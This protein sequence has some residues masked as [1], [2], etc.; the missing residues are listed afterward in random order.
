MRDYIQKG[1]SKEIRSANSSGPDAL[2]CKFLFHH[3]ST[4]L[5]AHFYYLIPKRL[6]P[7]QALRIR[8]IILL[9]RKRIIEHNLRPA[10]PVRRVVHRPVNLVVRP[11]RVRIPGQ[12]E[13]EQVF[14]HHDRNRGIHGRAAHA[15]SART[16]P[17]ASS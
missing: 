2:L 9:N 12:H 16:G 13:G 3:L 15:C 10:R 6:V 5:P 7:K 17:G 11:Q 4:S 14:L 8:Q 1:N